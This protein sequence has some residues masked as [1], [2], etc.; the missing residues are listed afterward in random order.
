MDERHE[1]AGVEGMDWE[2]ICAASM[3]GALKILG[4]E[5]KPHRLAWLRGHEAQKQE[6]DEE[7]AR[8]RR[9]D[10]DNRCADRPWTEEHAR[11]VEV[12]KEDLKRASRERKRMLRGWE[13]SW[14]AEMGR[15]ASQ[16]ADRND[17]G[18]MYRIF[19]ELRIRGA[20]G[21]G[22][23][24]KETVADVEVEREAWAKHFERISQGRGAV[25]ERVWDAIPKVGEKRAEWLGGSPTDLELDKCVGA[26]RVRKASGKDRFMVEAL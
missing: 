23:G 12:G 4:E 13:A 10:R 5:Q 16:A 6:A 17:S 1:T 11:Q 21:R 15:R 26:M 19:R 20:G 14:W 7:V 24:G 3:E 8:T 22:D 2:G 18:E 9:A 25:S